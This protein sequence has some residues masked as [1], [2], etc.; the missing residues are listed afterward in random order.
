MIVKDEAVALRVSLQSIRPLISSWLIVDTGSTDDTEA[1]IRAELEG[2]PGALVTR[3][4]V[5]H[6]HNRTEAF[7]I[8]RGLADAGGGRATADLAQ[9]IGPLPCDYIFWTDA[10]DVLVS[11]PAAIPGNHLGFNILVRYGNLEFDRPALLTPD[12]RWAWSQ[13]VHEALLFAG[14]HMNLQRLSTLVVAPQPGLQASAA[15]PHKFAKQV[16]ILRAELATAPSNTRA[17]YY[18]AQALR[19]A[20]QLQ[21]A[22]DQYLTRVA[23][24]GWVEETWSAQLE[25]AKLKERLGATAA[26]VVFAYLQAYQMRPTRAESLTHLARYVRCANLHEVARLFATT[27]AA[28]PRP[29]DRL[30]IEF[31][32]YGWLAAEELALA[33]HFT[34]RD[35]EAAAAIS[36]IDADAI[37]VESEKARI[38]NNR[39]IMRAKIG[40]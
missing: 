10:K 8:A 26:E 30:F 16:E 19:D 28:I 4:W 35:A 20:G 39:Q 22:H 13:G 29:D 11:A 23:M 14:M 34:G 36:K 5:N 15:D 21:A 2:V 6:A 7:H 38:L 9:A 3:P 32:A 31:G 18:L 33:N 37:T 24:G 27:A 25:A 17:S 1:V 12:P 40:A